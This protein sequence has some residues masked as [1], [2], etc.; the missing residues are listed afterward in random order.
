[1]KRALLITL[2]MLGFAG[3]AFAAFGVQI[4]TTLYPAADVIQCTT[5]GGVG[6]AVSNGVLTLTDSYQGT[7]AITGGTIAGATINTS[8]IGVTTPAAGKFTT[9]TTTGATVLGSTV[10]DAALYT[11]SAGAGGWKHLA[12][13]ADGTIYP[14]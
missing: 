8:T 11:A 5:T 4:D 7:A 2:L 6:C 14:Y 1:M 9:L 13:S 3:S 10:V 12:I